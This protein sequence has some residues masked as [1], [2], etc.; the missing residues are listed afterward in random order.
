MDKINYDKWDTWILNGTSQQN[1]RRKPRE[2][3]KNKGEKRKRK[4]KVIE[5]RY[6]KTQVQVDL[7][8][9]DLGYSCTD[10][11]TRM[12]TPRLDRSIKK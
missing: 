5:N 6:R 11:V 2:K 10:F 9:F 4:G 3:K 1:L 8:S 7:F 12:E